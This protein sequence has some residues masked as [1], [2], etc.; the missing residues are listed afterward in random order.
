ML[1]IAPYQRG[2]PNIKKNHQY[3]GSFR[4]TYSE[5]AKRIIAFWTLIESRSRPSNCYNYAVFT[6]IKVTYTNL[7]NPLVT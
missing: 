7:G 1:H 2:D 4:T 6:R 5:K 3:T